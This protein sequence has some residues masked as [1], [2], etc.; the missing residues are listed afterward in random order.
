MNKIVI[1]SVLLSVV[2]VLLLLILFKTRS[3]FGKSN[4]SFVSE[5]QKEITKIEFSEGGQRLSL[6]KEGENWLINGKIETR[7]S[8][9]LFILRVLQNIKIK[10]PVSAE[11]FESEIT[12][13][14]IFPVRVKV[15]EKKKLLKT[16]LVYKTRSNTYGNIMKIKEGS[17]PFIVYVPGYE[18]DIGSGFTL[19]ELFWQPYTVFNLLPSE[20]TSV[21]FEN[22]SD[23]AASFSIVNK[24]HHYVISGLTNYLTGCDS[25]LVIRYL[26][27]FAWIP[28][29]SWA[30]EITGEGKKMV[31]S[32]QPLYRITVNT[33]GGRKTVLTL[34]ERITGENGTKTKDSDRLLGKTQNRDELFIM[35][36]FDIDPLLKK[37]SYFFPE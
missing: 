25:T 36:Y 34:W 35:R 9:I 13:K 12:G 20:I 15:Y 17:K 14:G 33:T 7:K 18:S 19:N 21:N 1:R 6:E 32:Q 37:R 11:L 24:N 28:F 8:G 27:Y 30:F 3:P 29:E 10:S 2:I 23:T 4:S 16:F 31:E 26:S 5:P 22:I